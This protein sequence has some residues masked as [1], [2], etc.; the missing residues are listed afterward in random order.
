MKQWVK[1]LID[2]RQKLNQLGSECLA[3]G[4]PLYQ[5]NAL[6]TQSKKVDQLIVQLYAKG[7]P[8]QH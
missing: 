6:Q 5:N 2:E 3:K 8:A 1:L 7:R 4:I